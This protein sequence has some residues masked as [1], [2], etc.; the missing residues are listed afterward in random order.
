MNAAIVL[1]KSE[2]ADLRQYLADCP[3]AQGAE[4]ALQSLVE[5]GDALDTLRNARG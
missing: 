3:S 1:L 5:L 2:I 4:E